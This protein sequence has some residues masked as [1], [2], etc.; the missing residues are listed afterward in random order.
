MTTA[1]KKI[2]TRAALLSCVGALTHCAAEA[3]DADPPSNLTSAHD[4]TCGQLSAD[5]PFDDKF[6]A[7]EV[8]GLADAR[9]R[10]VEA[11]SG[12]NVFVLVHGIPT[13]AYLW[14]NVIPTL[15]KE[16]RV[17]ALDLIGYG[18][19]SRPSTYPTFSQ[20]AEYLEA[21]LD[22]LEIDKPILVLHD[23]GGM[24]GLIYAANNPQAPR[25]LVMMETAIPPVVPA[26]IADSPSSCTAAQPDHPTCLWA[27]MKTDAGKKAIVQDNMFVESALAGDPICPPSAEALQVYRGYWPTP[28][29]RQP[30]LGIPEEIA[31]DG[32]PAASVA[33]INT[34]S[35]WLTSSP[36]PKLVIYATPGFLIPEPVALHA[37]ANFPNTK[38][39]S[40]GAGVHFL[41]E[42]APQAIAD[43]IVKWYE[44][45]VEEES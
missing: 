37:R 42:T 9:M 6:V 39:R 16:G 13:S 29:S 43:T 38:I 8:D 11:G 20:H 12:D 25:A 1:F 21:F 22:K 10:Y 23:L 5:F 32:V 35:D 2:G 27:F 34:F 7:L 17:I 18:E 15:E 14:R 24:A 28:E 4:N 19:S 33:V 31:I 40:I 41:Q 3:S 36:I 44:E 30:L 26:R 45:E